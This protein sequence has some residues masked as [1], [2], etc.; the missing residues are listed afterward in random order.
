LKSIMGGSYSH[1]SHRAIVYNDVAKEMQEKKVHPKDKCYWGASQVVRLK[2]ECTGTTS[3]I[4]RNYAIDYV[5]VD[6]SRR[7]NRQCN[8]VLIVKV[9]KTKEHAETE[10]VVDTAQISLFGA[11]S[12]SSYGSS[13]NPPG[14]PPRCKRSDSSNREHEV[15]DNYE[16]DDYNRDGGYGGGGGGKRKRGH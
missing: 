1:S 9:K 2:W 15:D 10:A 11:F 14:P 4:K 7:R 5:N 13:S 6:A 8:S 3:I 12:Q 16:D